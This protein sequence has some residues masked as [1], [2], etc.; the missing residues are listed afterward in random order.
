[1]LRNL[2][3]GPSHWID[4]QDGRLIVEFPF[5][6]AKSRVALSSTNYVEAAI[7]GLDRGDRNPG[8][9]YSISL[10]TGTGDVPRSRRSIGATAVGIVPPFDAAITPRA[11]DR[12]AT[13]HTVAAA[14]PITP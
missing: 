4:M 6:P 1:M 13:P 7:G 10:T 9:H 11:I 8:T 3:Y 14:A 12:N 5:R 2:S